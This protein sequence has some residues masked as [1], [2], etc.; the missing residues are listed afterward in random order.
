LRNCPSSTAA[1][2]LQERIGKRKGRLVVARPRLRAS[3]KLWFMSTRFQLPL[4]AFISPTSFHPHPCTNTQLSLLVFGTTQCLLSDTSGNMFT[5]TYVVK[6]C[7]TKKQ[8]SHLRRAFYPLGIS[9]QVLNTPPTFSVPHGKK[10]IERRYMCL[11][12]RTVIAHLMVAVD[13]SNSCDSK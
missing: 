6:A 2:I 5:S 8:Q 9:I 1:A 7:V 4:S 12:C 3:S 10:E 11:Y 13:A